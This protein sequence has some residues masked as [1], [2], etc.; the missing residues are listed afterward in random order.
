MAARILPARSREDG[1]LGALTPAERDYLARKAVQSWKSSDNYDAWKDAYHGLDGNPEAKQALA[2]AAIN[3]VAR[4]ELASVARRETS[5][6]ARRSSVALSII[7]DVARD[8]PA[9]TISAFRGAE[10][11][12]GVT[13]AT[14]DSKD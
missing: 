11:R 8:D 13:A 2:R 5:E 7:H 6:D 9:A 10:I 12:L 3:G 1:D 14:W 4:D